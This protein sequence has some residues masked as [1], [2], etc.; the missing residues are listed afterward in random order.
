MRT[1]QPARGG[2]PPG[3]RTPAVLQTIQAFTDRQGTFERHR[4]RYGDPFTVRML[5]GPQHLVLFSDPEAIKEIFAGDPVELSGAQGNE[6]LR[7]AMGD[8]S[9]MLNDG[10]AH[11]A[12]RRYLMPA[13]SPAAVR[14]YRPVVE[15]AA[16]DEV[17]TWP[18]A[19][20]SSVVALERM[21][22]VTLAVMRQVVLGASDPR[23]LT[24]LRPRVLRLV[25][26]DPV[27]V[28]GW[29]YPRLRALPPW[30]GHARN[31]AAIDELI[32]AEVQ[33]RRAGAAREPADLLDQL[34]AVGTDHDDEREPLSTHEIRDQVVTLL[35]AGYET[36][37]STLAWTLHELGRD[38]Q[39]RARAHR[40][41][42]E[43][44]EEHLE[45]C[46][47]E[48]MRLH[49]IIDYV[50]RT[51]R[52]DQRIGGVDLP[53]GATAA[54]AILLAHHDPDAFPEPDAFRPERFLGG[55]PA[56]HTFIPFGG[57]VR[58]CVGAAFALMEGVVVLREVLTR[59]DV[60]ADAPARTRLRNI[61]NVPGDGAPLRV[62]PLPG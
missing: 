2:L 32:H 26:V 24:A 38:E 11:R 44:D 18:Q 57:G 14:A 13:F 17:D 48:A 60:V 19:P 34:L 52:S 10:E 30:R 7:A 59:V 22:R 62:C 5:P 42:Q 21:S 28:G 8:R 4:S 50:A 1:R 51:L 37:A 43:G 58:R 20:G 54:P 25:E 61:T 23:R 46:V 56:A 9:V 3:P 33:Q 55:G 41:A 12:I 16:A 45:A 6:M 15:R 27:V 53:A 29:L 39:A 31:L 49:P 40:A 36:T 47:K 35:L